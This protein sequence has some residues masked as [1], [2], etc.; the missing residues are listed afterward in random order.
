MPPAAPVTR[1]VNPFTDRLSCLKSDMNY[2][3]ELSRDLQD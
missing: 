1:T 3:L 2:S